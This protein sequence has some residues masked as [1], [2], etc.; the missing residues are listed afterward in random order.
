GDTPTRKVPKS[1]KTTLIGDVDIPRDE[2]KWSK[3]SVI[4]IAQAYIEKVPSTRIVE[5]KTGKLKSTKYGRRHTV[6]F[7]DVRDHYVAAFHPKLTV[8]KAVAILDKFAAAVEGL[9]QAR[10]TKKSV[11][12]KI[13]SLAKK[14]FNDPENVRIGDQIENASIGRKLDTPEG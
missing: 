5:R 12:S 3:K 2:M 6:S 10:Y 13:R 4:E 7:A 11:H 14:A 9:K 1:A 8:E